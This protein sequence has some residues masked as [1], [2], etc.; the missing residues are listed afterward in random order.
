MTRSATIALAAVLVAAS[1]AASAQCN[2][3][4]RYSLLVRNSPIPGEQ[5]VTIAVASFDTPHGEDYNR[6]NCERAA[7]LFM[8]QPGVAVRYWC[9]D[10]STA[11]CEAANP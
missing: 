1:T 11:S 4:D 2:R 6:E 7:R 10:V 3:P 9:V 8:S 5:P